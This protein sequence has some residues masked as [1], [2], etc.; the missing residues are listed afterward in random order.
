M[1]KLFT[2]PL[3][4]LLA[5]FS[6]ASVLPAS[7]SAQV[8]DEVCTNSNLTEQPTVCKEV[9]AQEANESNPLFGP[10]GIITFII[11]LI[12]AIV[13]IASVIMIILG[14]FKMVTSG[15]NPQD[16]SNAREMVIYAV[17]GVVLAVS[18]QLIVR[19]FLEKLGG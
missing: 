13:G 3:L 4:T 2:L 9:Q 16:V 8:F 14:G 5:T 10:N 11:N 6:L 17:V 1:K 7:A 19:L 15:N 18:A 12:S